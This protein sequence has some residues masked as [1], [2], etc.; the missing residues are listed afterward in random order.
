M[1]GELKIVALLLDAAKFSRDSARCQFTPRIGMTFG[2]Q[3]SAASL[4]EGS[5]NAT[6][7]NGIPAFKRPSR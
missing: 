7:P 6:L 2:I 5:T 1:K 4:G 3:E